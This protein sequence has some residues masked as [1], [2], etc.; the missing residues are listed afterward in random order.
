MGPLHCDMA[1]P[2]DYIQVPISI[3]ATDLMGASV[4]AEGVYFRLVRL[5]AIEGPMRLVDIRR[6]IGDVGDVEHALNWRSSDEEPLFSFSWVEEWRERAT[7][8]RER[9]SAAGRVSAEKRAKKKRSSNTRSTDVQRTLNSCS[10]NVEHATIL[11]STIVYDTKERASNV[12]PP[13]VEP[14]VIALPFTSEE[15]TMIWAEWET[16]RRKRG[17]PI[18]E[19]ARKMQLAKCVEWGE[20]RAIAALKHSITNDYQGLYEPNNRANHGPASKTIDAT[21]AQI[22]R[23]SRMLA[24]TRQ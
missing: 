16:S 19:A 15:F 23:V 24:A 20:E 14:V 4:E 11:S 17:K 10:T 13:A 9:M 2:F 12:P 22:E 8:S 6:R 7:A 21:N 5:I 1:K 3:V 18:S